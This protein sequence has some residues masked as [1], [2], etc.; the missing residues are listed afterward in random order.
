M[1][2]VIAAALAR[3]LDD[4]IIY[5]LHEIPWDLPDLKAPSRQRAGQ[6]EE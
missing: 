3:I 4:L 1:S 5:F 6:V 2:T